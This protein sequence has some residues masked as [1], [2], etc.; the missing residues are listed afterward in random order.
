MTA[1]C[2]EHGITHVMN[3]VD[4]VFNMPIFNVRTMDELYQMRATSIFNVLVTTVGAMGLMGLGLSI[5]AAIIEA[6]NGT[7]GASSSPDG[8]AFWFEV[9]VANVG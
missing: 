7:C 1:L 6:H 5:V 2:Q 9:P 4:P 3:A 8:S